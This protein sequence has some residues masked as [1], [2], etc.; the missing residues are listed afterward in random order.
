MALFNASAAEIETALCDPERLAA[1]LLLPPEGAPLNVTRVS[2]DLCDPEVA[3]RVKSGVDVGAGVF[4]VR[5]ALKGM[6][7]V[8]VQAVCVWN[9]ARTVVT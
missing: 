2:A 9:S 4:K 3:Q 1:A 5:R 7:F 6:V 8:M